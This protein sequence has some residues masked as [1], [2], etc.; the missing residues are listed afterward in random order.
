MRRVSTSLANNDVQYNLR[1]QESK[2]NKMNNQMGSQRKI[3]DLR[4]DP[5]AAPGALSI[6]SYT[7]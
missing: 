6:L 7:G 2:A 1:V 4:D 5:L 3:Q